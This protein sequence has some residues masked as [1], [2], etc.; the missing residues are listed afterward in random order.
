[1]DRNSEKERLLLNAGLFVLLII[2]IITLMIFC[3]GQ[4]FED[5][6]NSDD[7]G[8]IMQINQTKNES[9]QEA[10]GVD[11]NSKEQDNNMGDKKFLVIEE[12]AKISI[13]EMKNGE[14]VFYDFAAVEKS[15]MTDNIKQ[16]LKN[17]IYFLSERELYEFLQAFSS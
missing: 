17:G 5:E 9:V 11:G 1:M 8:K 7:N 13:Y 10:V 14:K 3:I 4:G 12:N 15:L 6:K 2:L 16:Q